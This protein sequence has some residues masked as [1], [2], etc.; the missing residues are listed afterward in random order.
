MNK[1]AFKSKEDHPQM[2]FS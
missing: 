1:I 2:C